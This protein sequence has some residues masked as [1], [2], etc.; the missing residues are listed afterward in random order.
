MPLGQNDAGVDAT[1]APVAAAAAA[2]EMAA[3]CPD[4]GQLGVNDGDVDEHDLNAIV[5]RANYLVDIGCQV[6]GGGRVG[7]CARTCGS[8]AGCS[9]LRC[10]A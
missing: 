6:C 1:G 2:G 9:S 8:A 3:A 4:A 7:F 5:S 10:G